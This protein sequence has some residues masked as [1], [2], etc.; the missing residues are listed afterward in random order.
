MIT[1]IFVEHYKSIDRLDLR[2]GRLSVLV[3]PNAA[4]KSNFID[5]L[6]MVRDAATVGL[7]RAV[8]ERHGID[9]IRQWSPSRPYVIQLRTEVETRFGK[10]YLS[11]GLTSLRGGHVVKR[12]EGMWCMRDAPEAHRW[13][14]TRDDH[15]RVHLASPDG[16]TTKLEVEQAEEL[17]LTQIDAK[18][19]RMLAAALSSFEA[20]SIFPNV[21]RTPQKSS[22]DRRLS[23]N[24]DNFTSI[25]KMLGNSKRQHYAKARLEILS[26]LRRVM[27]NLE[28]VRIQSIGGLMVPVFRVREDNG[29]VHDFNVAQVSDGSLRVLGLL[30]ALYQPHRPETLAMEEPEQN[31][32]PGIFAVL[33]EGIQEI[34]STGQILVT[35]HSPEFL[36]KFDDPN[37]VKAVVLDKG[38]THV[39]PV[40]P[41][42]IAAVRAR[43]F[44]LG[45]LMQVE[46]LHS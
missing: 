43:L 23:S 46:G 13:T 45:E 31:I 19:F 26:A 7:D 8:A 27:P 24:G 11:F 4:G 33:A 36:D 38:V 37:V 30:T 21:L 12:E 15:G 29:R 28:T 44:S 14:Y 17:F 5:A 16:K 9:S 42:Q 25:F 18:N 3:G 1:R 40:H 2:L 32:N 22:S 6:R 10:G 41:D 20:Y 34:S 35:T 39:G